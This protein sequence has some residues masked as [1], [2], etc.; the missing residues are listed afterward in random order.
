MIHHVNRNYRFHWT[1]QQLKLLFWCQRVVCLYK[2]YALINVYNKKNEKTIHTLQNRNNMHQYSHH[3]F[4]P[5]KFVD[6]ILWMLY[7]SLHNLP[8]IHHSSIVGHLLIV[9]FSASHQ[10]RNLHV[11]FQIHLRC[12]DLRYLCPLSQYIR[13]WCNHWILLISLVPIRLWENVFITNFEWIMPFLDI[14]VVYKWCLFI[15]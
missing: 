2:Q 13:A 3:F 11:S 9:M 7:L 8:D 4:R 14:G 12:L 1:Q 6:S 15:N 10:S 5:H